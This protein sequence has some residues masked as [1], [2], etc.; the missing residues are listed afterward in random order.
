MSTDIK[1]LVMG[2]T[3]AL[4]R[5]DT[6]AVMSYWHENCVF[7]NRGTMQRSEGLTGLRQ[8]H[9]QLFS[10]SSDVHITKT[11]VLV[12]ENAFATEWVMTGV[13][14]GDVPGAPATGRPFR[15]HGAGVGA[16]RDGK[17]HTASE[18]YNFADFLIQVGL[19][20]SPPEAR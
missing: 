1:S 16:V 18:Y 3:E 11:N 13:H 5:H 2:W 14:T 19:L 20:P 9:E 4:N 15:I 8:D 12:I 6:D 7:T 17:L 10:L